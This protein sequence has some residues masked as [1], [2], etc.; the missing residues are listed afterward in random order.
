MSRQATQIVEEI[1]TVCAD[2]FIKFKDGI[3]SKNDLDNIIQQIDEK[4]RARIDHL[5]Q[6]HDELLQINRNLIDRITVLEG[7]VHQMLA[8]SAGGAVT[9]VAAGVVDEPRVKP[10]DGIAEDFLSNEESADH[11]TSGG[12]GGDDVPPPVVHRE[13]FWDGENACSMSHV[14]QKVVV[15]NLLLS[16]SIMRHVGFDNLCKGCDSY[17][18][19]VP[20][21]RCDRLLMELVALCRTHSF[22]SVIVHVGSNHIPHEDEEEA[23]D[24]VI[25]LLD[26]VKQLFP[27]ARVAFS[28]LL[29]K[30]SKEHFSSSDRVNSAV[31][32]FC[33][34]ARIDFVDHPAFAR[35]RRLICRDAVHMSFKGVSFME[36]ALQDS[37]IYLYKYVVKKREIGVVQSSTVIRKSTFE[38]INEYRNRNIRV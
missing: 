29:P 9:G 32:R 38:I 26:V 6:A 11:S 30:I 10:V 15:D 8:T 17:K 23:A 22:R 16:D 20:G 18:L 27:G 14:T 2:E 33:L 35:D 25:K 5:E 28:A 12:D 4:Y 13:Q 1:R 31:Y 7:D 3:A 37:L 34:G 19:V 21:A 24:A 36:R